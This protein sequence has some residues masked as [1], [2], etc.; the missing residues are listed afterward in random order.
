M[1]QMT[2]VLTVTGGGRLDRPR[3]LSRRPA[4]CASTTFRYEY[5]TTFVGFYCNNEQLRIW[6]AGLKSPA[7]GSLQMQ[8][9][10]KSPA[11][12]HGTL[13]VGVSQTAALNRGHHL[14]SAGRPSRW[15]LA[16]IILQPLL[17]LTPPAWLPW[18]DLC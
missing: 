10:K 1:M 14:Y 17:C 5:G 16:H 7:R 18:D 11:S 15:A 9:P 3:S 6:N 4:H 2:G 13:V 12:L 8:D